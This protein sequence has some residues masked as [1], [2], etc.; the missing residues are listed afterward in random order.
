MGLTSAILGNII[1][2]Q[3]EFKKEIPEWKVCGLFHK[4]CVFTD[5]TVQSLAIGLTEISAQDYSLHLHNFAINSCSLD[6][7]ETFIDG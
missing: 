3:F 6:M 7:E 4:S 1:G 5:D 2:S